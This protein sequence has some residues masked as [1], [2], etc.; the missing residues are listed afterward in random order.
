VSAPTYDG[1]RRTL[2]QGPFAQLEAEEPVAG[3]GIRPGRARPESR[4]KPE[5]TGHRLHSTGYS[6][7]MKTKKT[8]IER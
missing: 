1:G 7:T 6:T 4:N 3:V 8:K 5:S 2:I